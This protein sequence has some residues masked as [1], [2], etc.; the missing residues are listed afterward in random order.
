MEDCY[1]THLKPCS[2]W[3][4][5]TLHRRLKSLVDSKIAL[6][7]S[8]KCTVL[9]THNLANFEQ[10]YV[11]GPEE[12]FLY[13]PRN[14]EVYYE[15]KTFPYIQRLVNKQSFNLFVKMRLSDY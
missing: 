3:D 7:C 6:P 15:E 10:F 9:N 11:L 2:E 13:K 14:C 5:Q 4:F 12:F 8:K 1:F